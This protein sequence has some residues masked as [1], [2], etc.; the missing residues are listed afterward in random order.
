MPEGENEHLKELLHRIAYWK[1]YSFR[2]VPPRPKPVVKRAVEIE[3]PRVRVDILTKEIVDKYTLEPVASIAL[4]IPLSYNRE[5]GVYEL[6]EEPNRVRAD[7]YFYYYSATPS[8]LTTSG[9][10]N[11]RVDEYMRVLTHVEKVDQL[12]SSLTA[13]DELKV[14]DATVRD[15]TR[16]LNPNMTWKHEYGEVTVSA[17]SSAVVKD[18]GLLSN[19]IVLESCQI[20]TNDPD[21][22]VAISV[23]DSLGTAIDISYTVN[24]AGQIQDPS[25]SFLNNRTE[26]KRTRLI[27]LA[28]YDTTNNYYAFELREPVIGWGYKLWSSNTTASDQNVQYDVVYR[29][30]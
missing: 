30:L 18:T 16:A 25:A 27:E 28:N 15:Y 14:S 11:A 19:P 10:Y 24:G 4:N 21:V 23:Y 1:R 17:N 5:K 26:L 9:W 7:N 3:D 12:P 2:L 20:G 13:T 8:A 6:I 29:E 22:V